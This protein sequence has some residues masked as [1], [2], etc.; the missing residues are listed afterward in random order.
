MFPFVL[1]LLLYITEDENTRDVDDTPTKIIK[2]GF[3]IILY[4]IKLFK[5]GRITDKLSSCRG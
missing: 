5:L 1:I 3:V 4:M 2:F